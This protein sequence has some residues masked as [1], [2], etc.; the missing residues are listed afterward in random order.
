MSAAPSLLVP[1]KDLCIKA[2]ASNFSSNPTNGKL[3]DVQACRAVQVLPLDLPLELAAALTGDED[4]WKKRARVRWRNCVVT[5]HGGSWKQLYMEQNL[6]E[7]LE[8]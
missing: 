7:A 6:Q 4:Y 8:K 2:V 3:P 1:L 5:A